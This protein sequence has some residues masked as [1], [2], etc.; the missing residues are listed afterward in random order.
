MVHV[1]TIEEQTFGPLYRGVSSFQGWIYSREHIYRVGPIS[2]SGNTRV[3]PMSG[4]ALYISGLVYQG[5]YLCFSQFPCHDQFPHSCPLNSCK[6]C[7]ICPSLH[8]PSCCEALPDV[9]AHNYT[10]VLQDPAI[11]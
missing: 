2:M 3:G 8:V 5:W 1:P 9:N 11:V 6:S 4:L 7:F 10:V